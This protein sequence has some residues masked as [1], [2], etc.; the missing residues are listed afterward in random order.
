M[1]QQ[2]PGR[3][4]ICDE[5]YSWKSLKTN[6][7]SISGFWAEWNWRLAKQQQLQDVLAQ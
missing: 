5:R 1:K 7:F 4:G 2:K 3:A 6:G